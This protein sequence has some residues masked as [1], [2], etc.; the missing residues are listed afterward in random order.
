MQ[1]VN[2]KLLEHHRASAITTKWLDAILHFKDAQ[3]LTKEMCSVMIKKVI[4]NE[5]S[6]SIYFTFADEYKKA[7]AFLK[8]YVEKSGD[9]I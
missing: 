9:I 8:N 7:L 2:E 4:L 3:S 6:V 1:S 5:H